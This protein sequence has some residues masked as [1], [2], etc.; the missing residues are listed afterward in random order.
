ML[1]GR[2]IRRLILE[3]GLV[4]GYL[5]LGLQVQPCGFDLSLESVEEFLGAGSV[6][7][8]NE[9]RRLPET[10]KVDPSAEGWYT[11]PQ[12]VY[13]V[14]YNET[15]K[16]PLNLVALAQTR[17]TLL[18]SG[19]Q[20]A[21]AVWDPGYHGRSSSLLIVHNPHG[22]RLKRGARIAQLVFFEAREVEEGYKGQYQGERIQDFRNT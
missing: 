21:T 1:S 8:S 16:I 5:D 2:E 3:E 11:L 7:F 19:A 18:R 6:D 17:S 4:T 12:G 9:E 15:V 20:V 14:V 22:L 10:R 13:K